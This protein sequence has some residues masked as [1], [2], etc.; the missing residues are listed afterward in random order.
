M[1]QYRV[2]KQG[3][4]GNVPVQSAEYET[5]SPQATSDDRAYE[6]LIKRME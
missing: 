1:Y 5:S 3:A 4:T 6:K 2:L